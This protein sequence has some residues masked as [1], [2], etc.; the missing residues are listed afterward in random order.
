MLCLL[1]HATMSDIDE[2][3]N[4]EVCSFYNLRYPCV[5]VL[6]GYYCDPVSDHKSRNKIIIIGM[7]FILPFLR[8]IIIEKRFT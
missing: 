3:A 2:C 5:N 1:L 7:S 4:L 6:G 8:S